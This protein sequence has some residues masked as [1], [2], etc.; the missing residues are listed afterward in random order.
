MGAGL[1]AAVLGLA[2]AAAAMEVAVGAGR[3]HATLAAARDA[4]RAARRTGQQGPAVVLVHE[5]WRR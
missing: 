1:L 3:A 2:A 4:I 5:V